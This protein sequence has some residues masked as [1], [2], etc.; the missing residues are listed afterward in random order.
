MINRKQI[1][2][3][4]VAKTQLGLDDGLY[5]EILHNLFGAASSK[6]LTGMQ[7]NNLIEHFKRKGF[8]PKP[9]P[10]KRI[11]GV[12]GLPSPRQTELIEILKANIMWHAGADG[13]KLWL[14][15]RMHISKITTK[16]DAA[17]VIE[18]L[19]GMIGIDSDIIEMRALPFPI[20]LDESYFINSRTGEILPFRWV[21]DLGKRRL[22]RVV[23]EAYSE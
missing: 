23:N 20:R 9:Q 16:Q 19:K 10:R 11:K 1:Q 8:K 5:R 21:Y 7:A 14:N 2:L 22:M 6:E 17:R 15:K 12:I 4:H 3:L 13:F 18:G